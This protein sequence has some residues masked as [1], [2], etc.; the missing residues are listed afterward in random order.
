MRFHSRAGIFNLLKQIAEWGRAVVSTALAITPGVWA[1]ITSGFRVLL[2]FRER[3][4][5][6][7]SVMSTEVIPNDILGCRM[8]REGENPMALTAEEIFTRDVRDLPSSERL[9]LAAII[10]QDLTHSGAT[11]VE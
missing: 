5:I 2:S 8:F 6:T 3:E 10:L 11:V 9:R 4:N 7:R 1:K